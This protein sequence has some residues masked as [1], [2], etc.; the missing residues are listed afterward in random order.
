MG[1]LSWRRQGKREAKDRICV[2][3]RRRPRAVGY[4]VQPRGWEV[5]VADLQGEE[6]EVSGF[7]LN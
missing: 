2:G 4:D 6:F 7:G 5:L 1:I 3:K